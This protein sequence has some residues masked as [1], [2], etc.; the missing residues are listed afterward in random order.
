[1]VATAF[2]DFTI[3]GHSFAGQ[4]HNVVADSH[5][6]DRDLAFVDRT[7][8]AGIGRRGYAALAPDLVAEILSPDDRPGEVLGKVGEWLEAG[9]RLVWV[10]DPDRQVASVYRDDGSVMTVSSESQLEGEAVLPGLAFRLSE[11]FE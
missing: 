9:V 4:H 5:C 7:R 1:M 10:I 6:G 3:H 11:L 8:V 2:D